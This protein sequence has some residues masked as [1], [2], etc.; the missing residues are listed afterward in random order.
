MPN[1]TENNPNIT[2]VS[3]QKDEL[4]RI[5]IRDH[6]TRDDVRAEKDKIFLFG[7]N[8][9]QKGF[10]GQAKEMRGEEN[11]LG[12]P[13]KK[14][15]SNS[16]DAFFTDKEFA[17][18]IKAIDEAFGKIPPDKVVVIPKAGLG[19]GLAGLE[20]KAPQTFAY[21]NEKL[22]DIGFTNPSKETAKNLGSK[23]ITENKVIVQNVKGESPTAKRLLDL[24][25]IQTD[26]LKVLSP[27]EKEI[28]TLKIDK[29][30]AL[31]DYAE[32]L[33]SDYKSNVNN[34]RD[35]LRLLSDS[36]EKGEQITVACSCRNG[37]MCHADVVK[38]AVEKVNAHLKNATINKENRNAPAENLAVNSQTKQISQ[39]Q[40]LNPR[41]QRAINEI[42]SF[43]EN[44]RV[45]E[46]INETDGRNR[47]EQ[48]SYL[49]QYSQL[50]RDIYE[51]GA[52]VVDGNL[53]VPQEKLTDSQPLRMTTESYAVSRLNKILQNEERAKE[54][55]PVVVEYGNKIGG[56]TADGETKLK[57]FGWMYDSLEG[58]TDFGARETGEKPKF[59]ETLEKIK[60][61][62]EEMHSLEPL[63]KTEFVPLSEVEREVS[64]ESFTENKGDN[65]NQAEIYEEAINLETA[66]QKVELEPSGKINA[67]GFERI[68]L[69]ADVPRIPEDYTP[70][71]ITELINQTLPEI[72]RKL[73]N[74][75][76]PKEILAPYNWAIRQSASEDAQKRLEN[77]YQKQRNSR[78]EPPQSNQS[79]EQQLAKIDLRRQNIIEIKSPNE[80][81]LA[82]KEAI[83]IFYR[84]QKMEIGNLL[85]KID[86]ARLNQT[87][88]KSDEIALKKELNQVKEAKP[89]FA[90]K[91]ENSSELVVGFPSKKSV[92]DRNFISSYINYQLKQPETRLRFENERY[93]DFAVR[94]ESVAT[95]DDVMK[96]SSEI[97]AENAELGFKWR[98][99]SD[100]EKEKLPRPLTSKEMQFL[101]TESSPAHYTNEMTAIRL[102]FAHSGAIRRAMTESL[103][104]GE[105]TPSPEAQK[106][107]GSLESRLQRREITHS[108]L[109]TKHF[110]E[111]VKVP[112]DSLKY[113]NNF[114]HREI[115]QKLPPQE[116]DF[117]Y[118]KA[119][120]QKENLEY[121]LAFKNERLQRK[122]E[123]DLS[124][125]N[126]QE[127]GEKEKS[128]HLLS[129]FNQA[130][131]L[132]SKMESP[133]LTQKE[134]SE[135][136]VKAITVLLKNHP[137]EKLEIIGQE[138]QK[139]QNI[140]NK[141]VGEVLQTF[142]R[143]EISQA[144]N[145]TNISIKL[146]KKTLVST[147]TYRELLEKFYP[148]DTRENEKYKFENFSDIEISRAREKGQ[149]ETLN[150]F[151]EEIKSNI[152]QKDD[153]GKVIETET[154][155]HEKLNKI[156]KFQTEA[157]NALRENESIIQKYGARANTKT[158]TQNRA[159]PSKIT[160]KAIVSSALGKNPNHFPSNKTNDQFL[161]A[162]QKEM[163]ITDLNKFTANE[164]FLGE[165]KAN[166]KNEF[167]EIYENLK[168]LEESKL[169]SAKTIELGEKAQ[170]I[171]EQ[172][173]NEKINE[174]KP[175]TLRIFEKELEKTEKQIFGAS[176]EEKFP[177]NSYFEKEKNLN[178][179]SVFSTEER[180]Q[181]K[182]QAFDKVKE[183]LEPKEL[184]ADN[185][186]ISPEAS[187]QAFITY[188][189]LERASNLLQ[190]SNDKSK[191]T[192]A[193]SKLDRESAILNQIRQDYNRNEKMAL[194]REGIKTDLVDWFKKN[195][196]VKQNISEG[197]ISKIL[198]Q[199]FKQSGFKQFTNDQGE[200]S[201]LSRQI[202][203]K[204]EA[205]Q[206]LATKDKGISADS[207]ET[208]NPTKNHYSLNNDRGKTNP[209]EKVK[210][211]NIYLR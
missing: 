116:K 103:L 106:L 109:A 39:G 24:N 14:L 118:Q 142:A 205:K 189:Q 151:R 186:K 56:I 182:E 57:V 155:V 70:T 92:E 96:T 198:M 74:G 43:S 62:A 84:Q 67:E 126:K 19:T 200:I 46:K 68:E 28:D 10:G 21:L 144:E 18:N 54:L 9:A 209:I 165:M 146:P 208:L 53:I 199:K 5:E 201:I 183:K 180:N 104:K 159:I 64:A 12:I 197:Q 135:T 107:I 95:R 145:K 162:V 149:D 50:T 100:S 101:F 133:I 113:K 173:I 86:N 176:L 137:S 178:P 121:R 156:A 2:L 191:I 190:T 61:L 48:A 23:S 80:Y 71:E 128:F 127:I 98:D 79:L 147:E 203:E 120:Q 141:T 111:S 97:R 211:V 4:T 59:E 119:T 73:E 168:V 172:I 75:F 8:L 138:L 25:N 13:T 36:L 152:Y 3:T 35:G 153:S 140:E 47:S 7:D 93:R 60:G 148:D 45:L 27:T 179:T 124:Q 30:Q 175:F 105:I 150:N 41:T 196:D 163:T 83:N 112:N 82:E 161:Q 34:F 202:T 171:S 207:R 89:N 69:R 181:I 157:R 139:S 17:A 20:E 52:N 90:F 58:K 38:M 184:G 115:Y 29:Q 11:S 87:G 130:R 154:A 72:D 102:S 1:N 204:I 177:D 78:T 169:Q 195:T 110:F 49:G 129:Q 40:N 158:Q 167:A 33:R 32:R 166:I 170:S 15:P 85:T 188:K 114:D 91:L 193:F 131:I 81:L 210:D 42:L 16:K 143:A 94:L 108:L 6:I 194:L 185:R 132:G 44:D 66:E 134:I 136:N 122:D 160:Q 117:V 123:I 174:N 37:V 26:S 88:E 164:K 77:I 99:L 22:A 65:L 51:R 31:A 55:A 125:I 63:D 192:E 76:T 206:I 187:Q